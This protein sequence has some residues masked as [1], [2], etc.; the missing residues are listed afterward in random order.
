[1]KVLH[2]APKAHDD[3][4]FAAIMTNIQF[5]ALSVRLSID[6]ILSD[7]E[8][9][10]RITAR[11]RR[12]EFDA[13]DIK[14]SLHNG[15]STE[16]LLKQNRSLL[17]DDSL[18]H[19][20]HWAFP[21]AYYAVF[22]VALAYFEA[23]GFTERSHTAVIKKF[24]A[25]VGLGRYPHSVSFLLD[26]IGRDGY[27]GLTYSPLPN[28]LS[29]DPSDGSQVDGRIAQFLHS[30][31]KVDLDARKKTTKLRTM[32]GGVR[33]N[34][35]LED[36]EVVSRNQGVT[37]VLSLLYRKR[38]KAN[39]RDIDT[40]LHEDLHAE[41]LYDH[42][43]SIVGTLNMVHEI[44]MGRKVGMDLLDESASSINSIARPV[45][46]DRIQKIRDVVR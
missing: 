11:R 3:L 16:Q 1:M 34:F 14:R 20:L 7:L 21:Q 13:K 28:S 27:S 2:S 38:I 42:L 43:I 33:K 17:V 24:G 40:F 45:I 46:L 35:R 5:H 23:S 26:G 44:M 39:Y 36:W 29:F 18:K 6:E 10:R 9:V 15:W 8:W 41:G 30:T 19:S 37:S 22:A 25:E 32:S 4:R 12:D 31:R